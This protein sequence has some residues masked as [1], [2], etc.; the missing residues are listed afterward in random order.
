VFEVR[1]A[2][3][4]KTWGEMKLGSLPNNNSGT[5]AVTLADGTHLII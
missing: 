4:G 3:G 2:D 5:D 1:S